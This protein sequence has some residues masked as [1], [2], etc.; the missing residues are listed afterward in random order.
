M[1]TVDHTAGA[2]RC[3]G[4]EISSTTAPNYSNFFIDSLTLS[5]DN[6]SELACPNPSLR[7]P[8]FIPLIPALISL[9]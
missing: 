2:R 8:I 6:F 5:S 4:I 7:I 9:R 1:I 3:S